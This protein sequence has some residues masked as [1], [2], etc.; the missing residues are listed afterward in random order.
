MGIERRRSDRLMLTL[1]LRV[2]GTDALEL[3]F[4]EDGSTVSFNR[5]G[6][7]IR[8]NRP[9]T[10]GQIVTLVNVAT[11]REAEF[12]VVGPTAPRTDQGGEW[13]LECL[14]ENDNIWG[15]HFPPST[16]GEAVALLEC[17]QCHAVELKRLS[18]VESEVLET[19]GI[20]SK[21]CGTCESKTPWGY[22]DK[23][24]ATD[25]PPAE[26]AVRAGT[27]APRAP[28][29]AERRRHRRVS[30]QLP[31]LVRDYQGGAEIT[32]SEDVSKGGFCFVSE[33]PYL[34]GAAVMV[35]CPY[36]ATGQNNLEVGA[37]IVRQARIEGTYRK[38]FGACYNQLKP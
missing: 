14:D 9:L 18:L 25:S 26:A 7:R 1:P 15:I 31:V 23:Q 3:D 37:R 6:V 27:A 19:S 28:R 12:R 10:I 35:A 36:H 21:P 34:P 11:H 13:A 33:K 8:L 20:L 16:E 5:H 29:G 22:A 32:K 30:L 2:H 4:K 24:V 17:R 38:I